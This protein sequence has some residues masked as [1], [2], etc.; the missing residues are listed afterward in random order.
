MERHILTV[1]VE[2]NFT[3]D[4]LADKSDW[5]KYEGQVVENTLR[6][7]SLLRRYNA[8]ATFFV[9]GKLAERHPEIVKYIM[10]EGHEIAS[11]SYLHKSLRDVPVDE[12][13][14]DIRKSSEILSSLTGGRVL[15]FR[16]MGYTIPRDEATFYRLLERYGYKY[17]SSKKRNSGGDLRT[18]QRDRIYRVFPSSVSLLG[19]R[20]VFSGG[21]YLRLLPEFIINKGFSQY[22]T[23]GQPVMLYVHPWEFNKDQPKRNVRLKY[24]ILQSPLTFSTERKLDSLLRKY[25]F[26]SIRKYIGV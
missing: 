9:V 10:D 16:A 18:I 25:E 12:L 14:A 19:L 8:G 22:R 3:F 6:I 15:G 23:S 17:D 1:D 5:P 2:D 7:L 13:E 4:E 11:H 26:V 24:K 20:T 21:T